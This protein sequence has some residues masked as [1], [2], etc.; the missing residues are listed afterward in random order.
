MDDLDRAS[1]QEEWFRGEALKRRKPQ[2]EHHGYCLN[3]DEPS[4]GAY[5]DEDCRDDAERREKAGLY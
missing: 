5:C 4:E 2:P 3:C 1:E